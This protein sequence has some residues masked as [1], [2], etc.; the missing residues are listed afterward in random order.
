[1]GNVDKGKAVFGERKVRIERDAF[2]F[3][4]RWT[5]SRTRNSRFRVSAVL[6]ARGG[7]FS[8]FEKSKPIKAFSENYPRKDKLTSKNSTRISHIC[9]KDFRSS[10]FLYTFF[11]FFLTSIYIFFHSFWILCYEVHS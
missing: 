6:G 7:D 10:R 2:G 1:M 8:M 11:P 4:K 3:W 9:R 5:H